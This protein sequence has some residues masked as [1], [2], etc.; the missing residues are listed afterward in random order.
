MY[1]IL[2]QDKSFIETKFVDVDG[3]VCFK[4]CINEDGGL[5]N[6]K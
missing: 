2:P 6:G 3:L 5:G 4:A 1:I